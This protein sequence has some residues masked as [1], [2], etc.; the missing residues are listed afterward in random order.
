MWIFKN[1]PEA[2]NNMDQTDFVTL[3]LLSN[4]FP[5]KSL[6]LKMWTTKLTAPASGGI[7]LD[8]QIFFFLDFL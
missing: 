3:Q 4:I 5:C 7:L 1:S 2:T 6:V 8:E